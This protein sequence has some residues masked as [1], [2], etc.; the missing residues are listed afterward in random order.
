M[1]PYTCEFCGCVF[2]CGSQNVDCGRLG[3]YLDDFLSIH[4]DE[5]VRPV[6]LYSGDC[7]RVGRGLVF[8]D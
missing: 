4:R 5:K 2:C 6:K 7:R 1:D 3:N 8:M